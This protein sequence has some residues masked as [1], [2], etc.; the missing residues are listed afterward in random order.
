MFSDEARERFRRGKYLGWAAGLTE[1][2][3]EALLWMVGEFGYRASYVLP[4]LTDLWGREGSGRAVL[5]LESLFRAVGGDR[6][7]L[8]TYTLRVRTF[9][10]EVRGYAEDTGG[11]PAHHWPVGWQG[12]SVG[13]I[14]APVLEEYGCSCSGVW[15]P[16]PAGAAD[17]L[18]AAGQPSTEGVRV[19]VGGV[20]A[21][22]KSLPDEAGRMAFWLHVSP[23]AHEVLRPPE[24]EPS[25]TAQRGGV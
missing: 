23:H 4:L 10:A 20:P 5:A 14:A 24:S 11:P 25:G 8:D 17:F 22:V 21:W 6:P 18:A 13:W 2:Q 16:H 3:L 15:W 1:A 9:L 7:D 19:S 12:R